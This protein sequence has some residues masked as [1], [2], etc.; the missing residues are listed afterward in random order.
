MTIKMR[1][2]LFWIIP[3]SI[4]ALI[5]FGSVVARS[6]QIKVLGNFIDE[7]VSEAEDVSIAIG[8]QQLTVERFKEW[9]RRF[10]ETNG[11]DPADAPLAPRL[12]IPPRRGRDFES[13]LGKH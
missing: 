2:R 5:A 12:T 9:E 3:W 10:C 13:V 7:R 4:I 6:S 11:L 1:E 8:K